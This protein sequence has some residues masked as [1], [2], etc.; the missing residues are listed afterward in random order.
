MSLTDFFQVLDLLS[1][2][3]SPEEDRYPQA[4]RP[5]SRRQIY[6]IAAIA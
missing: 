4:D 2:A 3:L 5:Y 6:G 1:I